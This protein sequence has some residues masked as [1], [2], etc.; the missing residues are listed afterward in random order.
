MQVAPTLIDEIAIELRRALPKASLFRPISD[1]FE[2][3][4]DL[5]FGEKVG[6]FA[7]VQN[8]V[9]VL[10]RSRTEHIDTCM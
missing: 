7:S 5:I 6:D 1:A 3:V 2:D 4:D 8:I 10:R 9:D